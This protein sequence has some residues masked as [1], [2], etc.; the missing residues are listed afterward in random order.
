MTRQLLRYIIPCLATESAHEKTQGSF[1]YWAMHTQSLPLCRLI[2]AAQLAVADVL[3]D[4]FCCN[5]CLY[6]LGKLYDWECHKL[7]DCHKTFWQGK[8]CLPSVG[9]RA[10]S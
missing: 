10:E 8:A 5:A 9:A 1:G 2:S 6:T 7:V 3:H 4:V